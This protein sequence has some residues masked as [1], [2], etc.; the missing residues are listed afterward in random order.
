[1]AEPVGLG[2]AGQCGF[3]SSVSETHAASMARL[4]SF[5]TLLFVFG[6]STVAFCRKGRVA[7]SSLFITQSSTLPLPSSFV[8]L[9]SFVNQAYHSLLFLCG[10]TSMRR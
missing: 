8:S 10:F 6:W 5:V 9:Y 3:E 4:E 1:M 2:L 7:A